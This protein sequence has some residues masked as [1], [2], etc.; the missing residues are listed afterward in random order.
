MNIDP[1]LFEVL[2]APKR[3]TDPRIQCI[4]D[5]RLDTN[6]ILFIENKDSFEMFP[7]EIQCIFFEQ[8]KKDIEIYDEE[9]RLA[10]R[11]KKLKIKMAELSSKRKKKNMNIV[12]N[13]K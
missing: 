13:E 9:K 1:E 6:H 3:K 2:E 7:V 12:Y 8:L 5:L 11:E 4:N 10:D